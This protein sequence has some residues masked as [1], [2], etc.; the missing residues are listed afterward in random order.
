M[1]KFLMSLVLGIGTAVAGVLVWRKVEADRQD[2]LWAEA[3]RN[4]AQK[5]QADAAPVVKA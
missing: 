5:A 3:E 2:D 1:K 4:A